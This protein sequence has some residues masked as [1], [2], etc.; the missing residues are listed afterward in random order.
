[1]DCV[2][3]TNASVSKSDVPVRTVFAKISQID[4]DAG[5]VTNKRVEWSCGDRVIAFVV[6]FRNVRKYQTY[7]NELTPAMLSDLSSQGSAQDLNQDIA[8]GPTTGNKRAAS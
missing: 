4:I 8:D 1:M 7:E 2:F 5:E 6:D 3:K